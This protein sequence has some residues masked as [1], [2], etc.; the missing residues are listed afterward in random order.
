[1]RR[2]PF[3]T[4][5]TEGGLFPPD[6]LQRVTGSSSTIPGLTTE[7]YHLAGKEKLNEAASRAWN[8]L[9][10]IWKV[11]YATN[12][13][14][15]DPGTTTT[16]EKWLLPLFGELGYGRLQ[17]AKAVDVNGRSY[18]V[19][20]G[21]Q[22]VPIHLVGRN[23]DLDHRTAGVAGAARSSPHSLVQELLNRREESQWG[24][25]SNGLKMR[26]LRDNRS[27]TRQAYVEF[28]L[29]AMMEGQ[30]F[31]DFM[32]LWLMCHQS[33]VEAVPP[34]PCWLEKWATDAREQGSRA[35][36]DLR[37]SVEHAIEALGRGFL[38][39]AANRPLLEKLRG[40]SLDRQDYYRQLLRVVYRLM[41]LFV[42]EARELLLVAEPGTPAA[43]RY[44]RFYS[45]ARLRALA[46]SRRG[47]PHGDLWQSMHV[48]KRGL[49]SERGMPELGLPALGSFLW[50][51]SATPDLDPC[52]LANADLLDAVRALAFRAEGDIRR[53]IDWR[54][55]GP[56]ELGSVYE[57][58]LELHPILNSDAAT[59]DLNEA[60]GSERKETGSYY[61][62]TSLVDSLLD[63]ALDPVL[64][65]AAKS[66][67]A[68]RA[69][70][71]LKVC[72]PAC[73]S[74]HFLIAAAHR[75]ARQLAAVRTGDAEA[76]PEA[77]RHALRDVI[78]HCVY[79]VDVNEMAVELCKVNL[80]LEA[81]DPGRPLSFLDQRIQCGNSL[82]GTTPVLL[83]DGIPDAALDPIEG[84]DPEQSRFLKRANRRE[85]EGFQSLANAA[86]W[87][88]VGDLARGIAALQEIDDSTLDGVHQIE[89]RYANLVRSASYECG[90]LWADSWCAAFVWPK[91]EDAHPLTE[92]MFRII[93]RNP[94]AA[95]ESLRHEI[96]EIAKKYGF[97]HWH[98]AFP[99]VFAVP[100]SDEP[101]LEGPGWSGGFDVVLGN[102][103]WEHVEMK[104]IEWF[105]ERS[106]MIAEAPNAAAR[107]KMIKS[108]AE[109]D[110]ALHKAFLADLRTADGERHIMRDSGL[111]PL[112]GTGRI[113][114]YAIFSELNRRL[115]NPTGRAGFIVPSGIAT[116]DTTKLF[117]QDIVEHRSL[118]SL[119]DFE[120][121]RGIFAGVHRSYKFCLLTLSGTATPV[122]AARLVFFALQVEDLR[123][124]HRQFALTAEDFALL[125]PNTRT[126]PIFRTRRDA[127]LTKAIYRRVP[128]LWRQEPEENPWALQFKQGL[129]NMASASHLFRTAAQLEAEGYRLEGNV[130]SSPFDRY[131]P[132]YEAKML[133][134][135]DH[136]WS[137][138]RDAEETRELTPDEKASPTFVV[139]PRYWIREEIV[140]SAIPHYPDSLHAMLTLE[141][142][143][144]V[145]LL[146]QLWAA[147]DA[148]NRGETSHANKVF[149]MA[150]LVGADIEIT[151]VSSRID[152]ESWAI[153]LARRF[154]LTDEDRVRLA[155]DRKQ[156][157]DLARELVARFSP[158]WLMGWRDICRSTDERTLIAGAVPKAAVGDTLLLMFPQISE[159]RL[160]PVLLGNL[161]SFICD[162]VARQKI[163]GTHL[164]YHVF[165]QIAVLPPAYYEERQPWQTSGEN[166]GDWVR[167]RVLELTY[168]CQDLKAFADDCGWPGS[169]FRWDAPRRTLL[170]AELD[171]AF[172]HAYGLDRHDAAYVLSATNFPIVADKHPRVFE[173]ILNIYDAMAE[174][175]DSGTPYK[176]VTSHSLV[177]TSK[178]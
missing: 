91:R 79:G 82:L 94:M 122:N 95:P 99:E 104:E 108:L 65:E 126:C 135:F 32:L 69:I 172:L 141:N 85:R 48:V 56:E 127:E 59:F 6:F 53:R 173:A 153:G 10:G 130:F 143:Q 66:P 165:R 67:D 151:G 19:S 51:I 167:P 45:I 112:C 154:P 72:D 88:R 125:N 75:I 142:T 110:P 100:L 57:S 11:F 64:E 44:S 37:D 14:A 22:N 81:L 131:L 18:P 78:S 87:E 160:L 92:D 158:N 152:L 73:G 109:E 60:A 34:E 13:P 4:I 24:F 116:D 89:M 155:G 84:D 96:R 148:V 146:L 70:L 80:W 117:F 107:K 31:S 46:S 23:I 55:L 3:T 5:K 39:H 35:L 105:S 50:N 138:Y 171:A 149:E 40:G 25:V 29:V 175:I 161:N 62:P 102:P 68:E 163:G 83:R 128:V 17:Q 30:A 93:E 98:L 123:D 156:W 42:A 43:E 157:S 76:S 177:E 63:S 101:L 15:G 169:P 133:H 124:E 145:S 7:A 16:R 166:F 176:G 132:L 162:Y 26:L 114:T 103:P 178:P 136:R 47:T 9:L 168:T 159:A 129:F 144:G 106:P 134:Q 21:W 20:H 118:A 8:R 77:V 74:G 97:F 1:M 140:E 174:A 170:R 27:L 2:Q 12:V 52:Q 49:A 28:D 71:N 113:N 139:Q 41:F 164:K 58:L 137:T 115:I 36:E 150:D 54:N 38:R 111:Y 147:G 61:T 121:R 120:N 90:W 86:P 33:R 119:Y